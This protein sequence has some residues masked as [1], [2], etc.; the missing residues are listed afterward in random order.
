MTIDF[1]RLA[2]DVRR[3]HRSARVT[4]TPLPSGCAFLH[5]VLADRLF[6]LEHRP[7]EGFGLG[8][9]LDGEGFTGHPEVYTDAAKARRR[10]LALLDDAEA[11]EHQPVRVGQAS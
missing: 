4:H 1:E 2:D 3:D 8:E 11:D 5:V 10:F 7:P 9:V 6:C